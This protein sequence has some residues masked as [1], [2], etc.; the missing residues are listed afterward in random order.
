MAL[1]NGTT[2]KSTT[3]KKPVKRQ[4]SKSYMP[5]HAPISV[6]GVDIP[7]AEGSAFIAEWAS[8]MQQQERAFVME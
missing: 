2:F 1:F 5:K 6:S 3:R 8:K 4:V 7:S